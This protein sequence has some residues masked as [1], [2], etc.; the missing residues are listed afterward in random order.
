MPPWP[1]G[2]AR[3]AADRRALLR[4]SCLHSLQPKRF[5][6]LAVEVGTASACVRAMLSGRLVGPAD[7]E[8]LRFAEADDVHA[9]LVRCGGRLVVPGSS[10]YPPQL[11]DLA[12]P[13][14]M[15]FV[16]GRRLDTFSARVAIVGARNC[17]PTGRDVARSIGS[18]LAAAGVTVV[19]GGARG[20]DTSSHEGALAAGGT[21]IAVL[22]CGIERAYPVSNKKLLE[23][24]VEAGAVVSEYPPGVAPD[25]FRFPARNRIVAALAEAV[26]VVEGAVGSGSLISADHALDLGRQVFSVPGAVNNPLAEVPLSLIRDGAGMIRSAEDLLL[27][28]GRI[29]PESASPGRRT[30]GL[31]VAEEAVLAVLAGPTLADQVARQLGWELSDAVSSLVGLELRGLVRSVGGRFERRLAGA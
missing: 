25:A 30:P 29:D 1:E 9:E 6:E 21:T 16:R 7:R 24:I 31:S 19:S 27:D 11:E 12:D 15:L 8:R 5:H 3:T 26:V 4:L 2:F 14:P 23:R 22:G 28:L 17:S 20:I 18:G 10:E 13:P